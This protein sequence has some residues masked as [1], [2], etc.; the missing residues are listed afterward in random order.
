M[1]GLLKMN[2]TN[3]RLPYITPMRILLDV[4]V[5]PQM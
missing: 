2:D 1:I 5:W 3:E 4:N